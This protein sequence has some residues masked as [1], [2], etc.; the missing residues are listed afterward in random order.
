MDI[1]ENWVWTIKKTEH[2][3]IDAFELFGEDSCEF[4]WTAR[5]SS[6]SI[7]KEISP[8]YSLEGLILKLK[9][10]YFGHVMWRADSLG[11]TLMLGKIEGRRRKGTTEDEMVGW[12]HWLDGCE[13][14]QALGVGDGR[15]AWRAAVHGG[16]KELDMTERL[17]WKMTLFERWIN[18]LWDAKWPGSGFKAPVGFELI[19]FM[20]ASICR[21]SLQ[22][23]L[24][25]ALTLSWGGRCHYPHFPDGKIEA[26]E[27]TLF[28]RVH[29]GK[30]GGFRFKASSEEHQA[31][32]STSAPYHLPHLIG[33]FLVQSSDQ[34]LKYWWDQAGNRDAWTGQAWRVVTQ[35][36]LLSCC[37]VF[38]GHQRAC[39]AR[40][41]NF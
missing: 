24:P 39:S 23:S 30:N 11:K 5:R 4:P 16:C 2:Q 34:N 7:L 41:S 36:R 28:P 14:E 1:R 15:E 40:S 20:M 25:M 38:K 9:L 3:R 35:R 8:E 31:L 27:V 32:P 21:I 19:L 33:S 29:N 12:H 6:Q 13:F 22:L 26:G 37:P 18:R 17:N 10:E